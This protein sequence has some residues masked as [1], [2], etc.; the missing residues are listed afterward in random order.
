MTPS[1]NARLKVCSEVILEDA[2]FNLKENRNSTTPNTTYID[3]YVQYIEGSLAYPVFFVKAP[4]RSPAFYVFVNKI[5][6][7]AYYRDL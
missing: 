5:S 2:S 3:L 7:C 6:P 1:L 4:S